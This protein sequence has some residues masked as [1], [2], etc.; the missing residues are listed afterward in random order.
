LS[1]GPFTTAPP[2]VDVVVPE[3]VLRF[4]LHPPPPPQPA[5]TRAAKGETGTKRRL[6]SFDIGRIHS[7]Y[8]QTVSD[9]KKNKIARDC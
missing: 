6:F 2:T 1:R 7:D 9:S 4:A 8:A 5:R 3:P